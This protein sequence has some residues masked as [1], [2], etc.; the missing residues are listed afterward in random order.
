MIYHFVDYK[1]KSKT[2]WVVAPNM[3]KAN[4][5]VASSLKKNAYI[6]EVHRTFKEKEKKEG[7]E[8]DILSEVLYFAL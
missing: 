7:R 2:F 5:F 1:D 4:Q 6:N 3:E 8:M